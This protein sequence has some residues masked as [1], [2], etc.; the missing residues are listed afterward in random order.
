MGRECGELKRYFLDVG[1]NIRCMLH[2]G[3]SV[4]YTTNIRG[5]CR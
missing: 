2:T 1:S 5:R 4:K 3:S